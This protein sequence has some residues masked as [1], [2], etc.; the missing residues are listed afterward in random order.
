MKRLLT[1]AAALA[2]CLV[3]LAPAALAAEPMAQTGRVLI[4]TQ[5][6]VSL[7]A[8]DQADVVVVVSGTA[9][10]QGEVNTLVVVDGTANLTNARLETVVAVRSRVEVG[11]GTVVLGEVQR[12]DATIHQAGDA[13]IVGGITD[14]A[15]VLT[16]F[17]AVL[18]PALVLL[19]LGFG[20][21][22]IVAALAV[23]GLATRQVREAERL[24]SAEPLVTGVTGLVSVLLLPVIAIALITTLIG[25]P[26]GV[27]FLIGV[28]PLV[29]FAGYLVAGIW[30]GDWI[31]RRTAPGTRHERPYLA[32][33][34]G[35]LVLEVIAIV[36]ILTVIVAI[37][38]I[39]GFGALVRLAIQAMRG[40]P[41]PYAAASRPMAAATQA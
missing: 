10:I 36:P 40:T 24:I 4:S 20:L 27:G 21:A 25:A 19:W 12:L 6:D 30:I 13:E 18:G 17:G 8:G 5:G 34:L 23:A 41:Q 31:L 2:L 39:V 32:A 37:A 9:D 1:V 29:A 35:V 26:L 3:A 15:G 28:L 38:S 11:A 16:E 33:V 14:L 7:P 22:T